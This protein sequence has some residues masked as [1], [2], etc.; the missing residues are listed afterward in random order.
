[1]ATLLLTG[2]W[3]DTECECLLE[4]L[5]A[6]TGA[7]R[8]LSVLSGGMNNLLMEAWRS[9]KDGFKERFKGGFEGGFKGGSKQGSKGGS[10]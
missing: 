2:S 5:T 3:Q 10:K 4:I 1:L 9:V 7:V 8:S 6:L